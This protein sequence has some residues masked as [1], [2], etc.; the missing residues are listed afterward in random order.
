VDVSI[1]PGGGVCADPPDST[2][3][4]VSWQK[5]TISDVGDTS[6]TEAITA[7]FIQSEGLGLP[8]PPTGAPFPPPVFA[9]NDAAYGPYAVPAPA[10]NTSLPDTLDAGALQ[11]SGPGLNAVALTPYTQDGRLTYSAALAPGTLQGG[12]YQVIGQGGSQVGAF[13]A[14]ADIPAPIAISTS[15]QPG[16]QFESPCEIIGIFGPGVCGGTYFFAWTGGDDRSIV[17][18]QFIVGNSFL[19]AAS[20]YGGSGSIAIPESYGAYPLLCN[21]FLGAGCTLLP[22]G[23]V[24]VIITQTPFHAPSQPFNAPGLGW[25]GESTWKYVWDFRGLAN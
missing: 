22:S 8:Q 10:C 13:T 9:S 20:A 19:A 7:Q 3:G 15:L 14:N 5:S 24:E 11:V 16:A 25:G 18:V 1:Q 4:I 17:T 6:S 21:T 12:D 2:L 23:N